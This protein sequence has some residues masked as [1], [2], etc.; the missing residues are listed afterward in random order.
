MSKGGLVVIFLLLGCVALAPG[1][2]L[3]LQK[4]CGG[5]LVDALYLVCGET[6][7]KHATYN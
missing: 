1:S 3:Q 6:S 7:G 2:P 4:L 5:E